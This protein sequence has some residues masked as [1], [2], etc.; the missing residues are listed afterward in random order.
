MYKKYDSADNQKD[1]WTVDFF[2]RMLRK[3]RLRLF[4]L[5][6]RLTTDIA[7]PFDRHKDHSAISD[8]VDDDGSGFVTATEV[9]RF[10]STKGRRPPHWTTPQWL[11]LYVSFPSGGCDRTFIP[12]IHG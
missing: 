11:A 10:C 9:N 7:Y 3:S 5:P 1:D 8:L 6:S 12:N 2:A 4:S